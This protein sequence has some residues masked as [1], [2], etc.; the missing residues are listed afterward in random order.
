METYITLSFLND[1][2]FCPR[3][4]YL[5]RLYEKYHH[6]YYNN[7]PQQAGKEAHKTIDTGTY[8]TKKTVLKAVEVFSE[9]YNI[10]GK[11]DVFDTKTGILTERKRNVKTIYDGYV[12]QV[13]AQY[14]GLTEMG[15]KVE[16]IRIHDLTKNKNYPIPLPKESANY[17]EKF[18][19]IIQEIKDFSLTDPT[20]KANPNKC[21]QCIYA[22]LCDYAEQ[23]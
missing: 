12:Y 22:N 1:F 19:K 4:I 21:K 11:I 5:H 23:E 10:F 8:S 15:Y 13:Y 6:R 7:I 17:L 3:S 20:F 9:Q 2:V 14:F 16:R 18:E